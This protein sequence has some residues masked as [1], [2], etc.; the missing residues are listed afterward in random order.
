MVHV[1]AFFKSLFIQVMF[2]KRTMQGF[3]YGLFTGKWDMHINTNP[4]FATV[5]AGMMKGG[6]D[7]SIMAPMIAMFGD[8][9]IWNHLKPIVLMIGLIMMFFRWYWGLLI[10]LSVYIAVTTLIRLAGYAY[11]IKKASR[12]S[13]LF[14]EWYF[15]VNLKIM[16]II[17]YILMGAVF[18]CI[19]ALLLTYLKLNPYYAILFILI[20]LILIYRRYNNELIISLIIIIIYITGI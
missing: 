10:L 14:N 17:K 12:R 1:K 9:F 4:Y 16:R 19:I 8:N 18:A 3:G 11:G 13:M 20:I 7:S 6:A 15:H 2:S 5:L